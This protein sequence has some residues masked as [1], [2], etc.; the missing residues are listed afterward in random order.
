M[1]STVHR[2][3]FRAPAPRPLPPSAPAAP[4]FEVQGTL[5]DIVALMGGN[6]QTLPADEAREVLA[7]VRVHE[8]LTLFHEGSP[9]HSLHVVRSGTMR[10]VKLDDDGYEQVVAFAGRGDVLG[11]DGLSSGAQSVTALALEECTLYALP[12]Q[13]LRRLRIR[14]AGFDA[15]FLQAVS[16]R[17]RQLFESAEMMAAVSSEVRLARFVL[18]MSSRM[19]A[20]G[21]SPRRLRLTMCRRDIASFL[22]VAHETVSRSFGTLAELGCLKV[23]NR[24]IEIIDMPLLRKQARGTRSAGRQA[25]TRPRDLPPDPAPASPWPAARIA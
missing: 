23:V 3:D 13:E 9:L 19:A 11:F 1:S 15:A 18:W 12:L 17:L 5:A 10:C 25:S 20:M 24:E 2:I 21:H 16:R 7:L 6:A 4:S 8:G 14:S 22:A